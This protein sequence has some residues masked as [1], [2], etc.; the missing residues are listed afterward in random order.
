M[1]LRKVCLRF[2]FVVIFS[3]FVYSTLLAL[4][5]RSPPRIFDVHLGGR[6]K[7]A[8]PKGVVLLTQMRSG[9]S[10]TGVLLTAAETTFYSEE[11]VRDFLHFSPSSPE[12]VAAAVQLLRDVLR[13]RFVA[14]PDYYKKRLMLSHYHDADTLS[15]CSFSEELCMA[16]LTTQTMC[17]AAHVRL[18][19]VVLLDLESAAPVFQDSDLDTHAIHLVRDPRGVLSSRGKLS[20]Y[21]AGDDLNASSLCDRY[22]KDLRG[23]AAV[24]A[25]APHR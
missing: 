2:S 6:G 7:H 3:F 8:P 10:F 17:L 14:R 9:S 19:R 11:P 24:K 21:F 13:C 1:V 18:A 23:A 12:D 5:W 22:R 15:L 20:K 16:P 25:S 4:Q